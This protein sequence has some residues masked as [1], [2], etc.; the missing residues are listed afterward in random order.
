MRTSLAGAFSAL[1][2]LAIAVWS[3]GVRAQVPAPA[4]AGQADF[5]APAEAPA[6]PAAPTTTEPPTAPATPPAPPVDAAPSPAP[7]LPEPEPA[8]VAPAP[9]ERDTS[10]PD[11]AAAPPR[12]SKLF[13]TWRS[14]GGFFHASSGSPDDTRTFSG[15]SVSGQLALGGRLGSRRV[16]IGGMYLQDTVRGLSSKD[17]R[18]DGDEPNLKDIRFTFWAL[19]FFTDVALQAE[20]GLHFQALLG[21]GSLWVS[22]AGNNNNTPSDPVGFIMNAGVGY[23]FRIGRKLAVG[24]LLRATY[25]PLDVTETGT[26]TGPP[27][28]R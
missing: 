21:V 23:D 11:L 9:S 20:P 25:A 14:G 4:P 1:L 6:E 10:S 12:A 8:R 26:R 3:P 13:R 2:W 15:G 22:R 5:P 18:I 28:R 24:A 7:P 27:W 16:A 17:E 19:G